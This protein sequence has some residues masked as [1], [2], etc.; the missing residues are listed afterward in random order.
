L[1]ENWHSEFLQMGAYV[2]LTV[3]LRQ[4]GS[5]ESKPL[6]GQEAVDEDPHYAPAGPQAPWPMP[7][8]GVWL[9]VD[10]HSLTIA[11]FLLIIGEKG[12]TR[13]HHAEED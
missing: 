2:L 10:A 6:E 13:S 8:G 5:P 7:H 9:A 11:L 3:F 1:G 12:L 4:K